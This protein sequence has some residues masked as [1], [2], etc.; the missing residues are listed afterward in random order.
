MN[1]NFF[2]LFTVLMLSAC[3]T[4]QPIKSPIESGPPEVIKLDGESDFNS[5]GKLF[6]LEKI[7]E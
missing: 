1:R 5:A 4:K 2:V 3:A 6:Y 7:I